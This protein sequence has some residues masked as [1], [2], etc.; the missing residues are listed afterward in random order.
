MASQRAS[1]VM[2]WRQSG[3]HGLRSHIGFCNTQFLEE[4][5]KSKMA[6]VDYRGVLPDD[7][8]SFHISASTLWKPKSEHI[9]RNKLRMEATE[10]EKERHRTTRLATILCEAE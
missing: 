1:D 10:E 6:Y 3:N 4:L 9:L 8:V 7:R 5:I 2:V